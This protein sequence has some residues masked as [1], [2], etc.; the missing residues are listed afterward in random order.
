MKEEVRS[1]VQQDVDKQHTE[2]GRRF[3][4]ASWDALDT[5]TQNK[6]MKEKERKDHVQ[7]DVF[8]VKDSFRSKA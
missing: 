4:L 7:L 8:P 2:R 1:T 6:I 3:N 5:E